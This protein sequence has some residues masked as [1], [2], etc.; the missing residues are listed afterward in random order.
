MSVLIANMHT[1]FYEVS[2]CIGKKKDVNWKLG[3][4]SIQQCLRG[5]FGTG[6][7]L[8]FKA[9]IA[10]LDICASPKLSPEYMTLNVSWSP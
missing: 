4:W 10:F 2:L 7:S 5:T 3:W 9:L 1:S 8:N 6:H